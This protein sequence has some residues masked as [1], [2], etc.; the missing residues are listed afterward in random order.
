[1]ISDSIF[2][3]K[4]SINENKRNEIYKNIVDLHCNYSYPAHEY[5]MNVV[6]PFFKE[7]NE[8]FQNKCKE[9]YPGI[10]ILESMQHRNFA[11]VSVFLNNKHW[12]KQRNIHD[13]YSVCD[14]VGVYYL[15]IPQMVD[16]QY[17]SIDFHNSAGE[18]V[19]RYFPEK[20]EMLIFGSDIVHSIP[21]NI[22]DEYR[23]SFNMEINVNKKLKFYNR[24][25]EI[26]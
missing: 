23:I 11:D 7:V 21:H 14:I 16:K 1:M 19:E 5:N 25:T 10:E 15:N 13:H 20:D 18:I 4:Y 26:E 2:I 8:F 3:F 22:D 6:G 24:A 17:T 9:I 12:Y